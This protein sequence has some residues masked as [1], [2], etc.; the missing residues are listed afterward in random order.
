MSNFSLK[1]KNGDFASLVDKL[2]EHSLSTMT[3]EIISAKQDHEQHS[4]V[5]AVNNQQ[6]N[7]PKATSKPRPQQTYVTNTDEARAFAAKQNEIRAKA[8]AQTE[9]ANSNTNNAYANVKVTS[10]TQATKTTPK[11]NSILTFV[12]IFFFLSVVFNIINGKDIGA[13]GV[14]VPLI[15]GLIFF[16]TMKKNKQKR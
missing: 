8:K 1:P 7:K 3:N 15:I 9:R 16:F 10:N 12:V 13:A 6:Q 14:A 11:K 5:E 4:K 2:G